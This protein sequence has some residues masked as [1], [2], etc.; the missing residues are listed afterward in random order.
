MKEFGRS[1]LWRDESRDGC[2]SVPGSGQIGERGRGLMLDFLEGRAFQGRD[3]Q[4]EDWF[5]FKY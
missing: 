3:F 4:M 1:M 5:D 2:P